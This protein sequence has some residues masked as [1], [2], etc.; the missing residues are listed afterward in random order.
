MHP[1]TVQVLGHLR[2]RLAT[3]PLRHDAPIPFMHF[4]DGKMQTDT[5]PGKA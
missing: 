5:L 3:G 1:M 4:Y 2:R